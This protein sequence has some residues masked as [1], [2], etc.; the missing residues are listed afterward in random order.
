MPYR[1]GIL[2]ATGAVGREMVKILEERKIAP[3]ELRLLAGKSAGEK[4]DFCGEGIEVK[5]ADAG[6]FAGLDIVLGAAEADVARNF[7]PYISASGAVFADNSSAFRLDDNVPLIVPEINPRDIYDHHGIIA[8]P[9]CTTTITLT[10]VNALCAA[11][12]IVEMNVSSYQAVSGAG[13]RGI[14]TLIG[15]AHGEEV[16]N[17]PFSHQ[18]AYNVIPF[19]GNLTDNG[20]TDEEMKMQN[21]GRRILHLPGLRASC[22]C[23]RVPV[24]RSHGVA[25]QVITRDE[26]APESAAKLISQAPGCRLTDDPANG[27]YPMPLETTD[28][29]LV[30][31][32][33]IRKGITGGLMLWC[34]ADQLRKGAATNTVQI[35]ELLMT[36]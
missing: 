23:V 20:Y 34:C 14:S 4:I 3:A 22:T 7:A 29:D 8:S 13:N 21:E 35:A 32:G 19:I 26:I 25:V 9:N 1:I 24:L 10:A 27:I 12:P 33:R 16:G 2:G 11:S 6:A 15:Q 18:I 30:Y 31:V 5:R 28:Q 36:I 17:G